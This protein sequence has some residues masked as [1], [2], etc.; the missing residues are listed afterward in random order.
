MTVNKE[1]SQYIPY[2]LLFSSSLR[3][4]E[5]EIGCVLKN[6]LENSIKKHLTLDYLIGVRLSQD[7]PQTSVEAELLLTPL[8]L[9]RLCL[10]LR[11]TMNPKKFSIRT[12]L[13]RDSL[14][15]L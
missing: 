5:A 10:V 4:F 15:V 7:A 6:T 2:S 12:C 13:G 1:L 8:G 9:L 3:A 14:F 11:G